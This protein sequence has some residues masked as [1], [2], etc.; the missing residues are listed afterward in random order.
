[1]RLAFT[2]PTETWTMIKNDDRR[3]SIFKRK[4]L[5]RIYGPIS[6]RGQWC[7]R[8]NRETQELYSE[9]DIVNIIKSSRLRWAGH[10]E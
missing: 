8:Y 10:V 7:K 5:H 9:P 1:M 4:I 6:K 3:L 2:D